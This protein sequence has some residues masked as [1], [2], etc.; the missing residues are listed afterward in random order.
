MDVSLAG[1]AAALDGL[2]IAHIS[3]L[4]FRRW[5]RVTQ[6]LQDHLV[7]LDYDLLAITGDF[8]SFRRRW[9]RGAVLTEKLLAPV[10]SKGPIFAVLG[11]H[12]DPRIADVAGLPLTFLCNQHRVVSFRSHSFIIAG[13]DQ[14]SGSAERL[15]L[16]LPESGSNLP[17]ILLAHYPSTIFRLPS[18]GVDLVLSGHTHGGQ[19]RF[20]GIG[21]LWSNDAI[22]RRMSRGLH[23]VDEIPIHVSAGIGVSLPLYIRIHCP[24]EIGLLTLRSSVLRVRVGPPIRQPAIPQF[25]TV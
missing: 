24:P 5:N 14:S 9:R 19:I 4:H 22:P 12:D 2:R 23:V 8:S 18:D 25:E 11:N 15:D 1:R 17:T 3:D 10:A 13:V 16:A 20:P 7:A 6:A 21:C